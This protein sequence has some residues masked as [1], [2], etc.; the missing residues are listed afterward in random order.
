MTLIVGFTPTPE[1]RAALEHAVVQARAHRTDVVVI[2]V[3]ERSD[4]PQSTFATDADLKDVEKV[5][6]DAGITHTIRQ[7][8]RGKDPAEEVTDLVTEYQ[9]DMVVIGLRRRTP[10]GKLVLGSN[11]QRILLDTPCPVVA[12]KAPT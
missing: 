3:S 7:L 1:G 12:V 2:N 9:A 8:V 10:V 5:L 6:T 4:P 11:S